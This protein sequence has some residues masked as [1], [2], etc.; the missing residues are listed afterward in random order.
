MIFLCNYIDEVTRLKTKYEETSAFLSA[1]AQKKTNKLL[2]ALTVVTSLRF[3][4]FY[5]ELESVNNNSAYQINDIERNYRGIWVIHSSNHIR[6]PL[7]GYFIILQIELDT[8]SSCTLAGI[9]Y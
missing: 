4:L 2:K 8:I 5:M 1:T 6:V 3:I 9:K 7:K